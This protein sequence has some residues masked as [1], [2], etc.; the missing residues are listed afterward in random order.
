MPSECY[1]VLKEVWVPTYLLVQD[2]SAG[3][4]VDGYLYDWHESP[5]EAFGTW[6][7]GVVHSGMLSRSELGD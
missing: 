7:V 5:V 1:P 6:Y 2:V 3:T 4:R